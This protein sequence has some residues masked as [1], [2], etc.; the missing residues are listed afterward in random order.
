MVPYGL[1]IADL[2]DLK[3]VCH[4]TDFWLACRGKKLFPETAV[5]DYFISPS[6]HTK[7]IQKYTTYLMVL[8]RNI[9]GWAV[10]QKNGSLIHFLIAVNFRGQGLGTKL[11]K[12]INPELIHSKSNQSSGDP[13]KFYEH[14]GYVKT[15]S[16][17]SKS[18]LDIDKINPDRG[19]I[20]D[21]YVKSA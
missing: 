1:K 5:N 13:G 3:D 16:V 21:I 18:R 10:V 19:K 6:Q 4:F 11:L 15:G 9:I 2:S 17:Q 14:L 20:I 8:Y 7:Y 12:H